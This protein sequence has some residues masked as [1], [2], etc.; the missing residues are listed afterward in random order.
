MK[1]KILPLKKNHFLSLRNQLLLLSALAISYVVFQSRSS[2]AAN[3]GL[4]DVTGGPLSWGNCNACHAGG[5]WIVTNSIWV[6]E[7][8]TSNIVSNYT[9]NTTYD[10]TLVVS[11]MSP[12]KG[13]QMTA[14]TNANVMAGSFSSPGAG[15]Q[16]IVDNGVTYHEH[17]S[18]SSSGSYTTKWTSPASGTGPVTFYM[19]GLAA[20]NP[21]NTGGDNAVSSSLALPE[22]STP[23]SVLFSQI[24]IQPSKNSNYL[25]WNMQHED[26]LVRFE[27]DR[28]SDG[29]N[30]TTI[31]DIAAKRN[32]GS[33][34][35]YTDMQ[36]LNGLNYYRI[37][38][39]DADNKVYFSQ[40]MKAD[41]SIKNTSVLLAPNPGN[42]M[43]QILKS[44]VQQVTVLDMRGNKVIQGANIV[45]SKL[46]LSN[47]ASGNYVIQIT[48]ES[49]VVSNS[50]YSKQ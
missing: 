17:T 12:R 1:L 42:G 21:S 6:F 4:G 34:Y 46:D 49:G 16:L 48:D 27:I 43:V 23:L 32:I 24:N 47:L 39:V 37:R 33:T 8:G 22:S 7:E 38:A 19:S 28:S 3:N 29:V 15:S 26:Q 44:N 45:N 5:A 50:I 40:V 35:Q 2:G 14:L 36:V 11:S 20:A 41:N 9:P 18:A 10:I 30:F 31:G 13:F 25:S